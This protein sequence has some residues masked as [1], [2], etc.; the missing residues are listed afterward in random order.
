MREE[1]NARITIMFSAF[2]G[3]PR[4]ARLFGKGE[5]HGITTTTFIV[6]T[7]VYNALDGR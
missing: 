5:L 7:Y 6:L 2:Q 1:G 4:I 3:P